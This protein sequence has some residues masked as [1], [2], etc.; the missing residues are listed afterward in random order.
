MIIPD[1]NLLLY[2]HVD[3]FPLHDRARTWWEGLLSGGEPVGMAGVVAFDFVR[4]ATNRRVLDR[5]MHPDQALDTVESWLEQ[6]N[7]NVLISDERHVSAS[8]TLLR[9]VGVTGNLTTDGQIA[10]HAVLLGGT[11]AT[12]DTEFDRF[13]GLSVDHPL[14]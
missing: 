3:G 1:L 10:G 12:N 14:R 11:V 2:A 9:S 8:F 5:P 6:P 13:P 4:I 7:V